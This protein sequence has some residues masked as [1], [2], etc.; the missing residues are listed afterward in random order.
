MSH[1]MPGV[2]WQPMFGLPM[3]V[4]HY[5]K[6]NIMVHSFVLSPITTR[7]LGF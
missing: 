2:I 3:H 1:A 4:V 7:V 6:T 5:L